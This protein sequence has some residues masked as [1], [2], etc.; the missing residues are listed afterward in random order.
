MMAALDLKTVSELATG[1]LVSYL[2]E[3]AVIAGFCGLLLRVVRRQNSSTRFAVWF[4]SLIA[5]AALPLL[6]GAVASS[7]A[8]ADTGMLGSNPAVVVPSS[9]ALYVFLVWALLA[10][11][12]L[13]RVALG[14]ARLCKLRRSCRR[15][16]P[17]SLSPL[18]CDTL[19]GHRIGRTV[20]LCVSDQIQSAAAVG[21][22]KP[23]VVIPAWLLRELSAV[24]LNQIL[25]HE[26]AHLRRWDDWTNLLQKVVKA[27]LFFHPAVWWIEQ[28][29]SLEREMACDDAVLAQ[30]ASPR[31]YAECLALLAEKSFLRRGV[32]FAQAAV[33][34]V[35]HMSLRVARILDGNRPAGTSHLWKPL[36][37]LAA[38]FACVWVL[39]ASTSPRLVGFEGD[40]PLSVSAQ[41]IP[42]QSLPRVPENVKSVRDT[43]VGRLARTSIKSTPIKAKAK[44]LPAASSDATPE[45]LLAEEWAAQRSFEGHVQQ[46]SGSADSAIVTETVFVVVE[47][48]P[49]GAANRPLYQISVWRMLV[50]H[51]A[52][53]PVNPGSLRKQI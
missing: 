40:S 15:V 42:L 13:A 51:P 48:N 3:G 35:R 47:G 6:N 1:Q 44:D 24:D 4:F 45:P 29:M 2:L 22:I 37:A 19:Q 20:E 16:D 17:A 28:K 26:L 39:F 12:G 27:L 18:L 11:L 36:V 9:W 14:L 52:G 49:S 23:A 10:S 31:A 41:A 32:A 43:S 30:T 21:L 8:S 5:M 46:A 25:L 34:R 53:N 50:V 33:G 7:R 38:G